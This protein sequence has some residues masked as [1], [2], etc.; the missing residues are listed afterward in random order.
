LFYSLVGLGVAHVGAVAYPALDLPRYLGLGSTVI[1]TVVSPQ[2]VQTLTK[3]G[4]IVT[5]YA[6]SIILT[7]ISFG[8][9]GTLM[10]ENLYTVNPYATWSISGLLTYDEAQELINIASMLCRNNYL[11]DWRAGAYLSYKYLRIKTWLRGFYNLETQSFFIFGGSYGPWITPEYLGNFTG[12]LIFQKTSLN[13][14]EVY[15]LLV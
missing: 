14:P 5:H 1:L 2:A 4:R 11:I 13:L 3:R 10:P 15:S 7:V 8:F 6:L 9:A 12:M